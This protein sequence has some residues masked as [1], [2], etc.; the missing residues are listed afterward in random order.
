MGDCIQGL[1][2][3]IRVF[4][5]ETPI[6]ENQIEANMEN[7]HESGITTWDYVMVCGDSDF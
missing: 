3:S 1:W 7:Q 2:G 4:Q 6:F 5:D